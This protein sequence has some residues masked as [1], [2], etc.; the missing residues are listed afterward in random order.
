MS[1]V[2]KKNYEAYVTWGGCTGFLWADVSHEVI[3][4]KSM[5][6]LAGA[7]R[8]NS[9]FY[10]DVVQ[11]GVPVERL[12]P[13]S[14]QCDRWFPLEHV[15]RKV[16]AVLGAP[17]EIT[18]TSLNL[19]VRSVVLG[20]DAITMDLWSSL[21]ASEPAGRVV[22]NWSPTPKALRTLVRGF[23]QGL[24]REYHS[25]GLEEKILKKFG[26]FALAAEASGLHRVTVKACAQGV[27]VS[28]AHTATTLISL[29]SE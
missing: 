15:R 10:V 27:V 23:R 20:K 22:V 29:V 9:G 19:S 16:L 17:F 21:D 11:G 4:K 14:A 5:D 12:V 3:R 7:L 1:Q 26:S 13:P 25:G 28:Q 8:C 18:G 2:S 6:C 24:G